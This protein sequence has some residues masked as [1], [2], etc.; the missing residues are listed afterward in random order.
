MRIRTG[1]VLGVAG[2]ALGLA[3]FPWSRSVAQ[4][5][6][7]VCRPSACGLAVA[8]KPSASTLIV[9]SRR[10]RLNYAISD[11]GPSGVSAVELW[12][13]RDGKSWARYSNEPPPDGPLV[14]HVAEEGRYGFAVVVRNGIGVASPAPQTGDQP[15]VWVVVDETKPVVKLREV[16]VG[17]GHDSG[18]LSIKWTATDERLT[19]RPVTI[20]M[21]TKKDGPWTPIAT[22]IANTGRH[23]WTMPRD[24]PYAFFVR[25]EATDRAGNVGCDV[26]PEPVK[27]D[28]MQPRGTII[29]VDAEKK[30]AQATTLIPSPAVTTEA[31]PTPLMF[32]LSLS[33]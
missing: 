31:K 33:R 6:D 25:V 16:A 17:K 28:L 32:G 13:T 2:L 7:S 24:Y 3:F 5:P 11:V 22:A 26:T 29:G 9:N 14:V 18:T 10:V 4:M 27:V 30:T 21:A 23:V 1:M 8:S 12:A 15:Q 19:C 20:S